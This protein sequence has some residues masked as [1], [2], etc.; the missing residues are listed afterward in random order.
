MP[1]GEGTAKIVLRVFFEMRVCPSFGSQFYGEAVRRG[2]DI[3]PRDA[4]IGI[5]EI[6]VVIG[7]FFP[8]QLI[9]FYWLAFVALVVVDRIHFNAGILFEEVQAPIIFFACVGRIKLGP[10]F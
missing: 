9:F 3:I 10:D 8:D 5:A 1:D 7:K 2:I 6:S 4:E